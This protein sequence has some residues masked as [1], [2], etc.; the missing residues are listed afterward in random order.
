[1]AQT[2]WRGHLTFGLVSFPVRLYK[3]ARAEKVS[4]RRLY[5]PSAPPPPVFDDEEPEPPPPPRR[6]QKSPEPIRAT[7]PAPPAEPEVFRTQNRIVAPSAPPPAAARGRD[8]DEDDA[9]EFTPSSG[10]LVKG[11]EYEKGRYVVLEDEELKSLVPETSKEMQVVEFVR[12]AE[13]DPIFFETSYYV[14]P[15]EAGQRPY[16]LLFEALREAEYVGLAQLAMHRREHIVVIRSGVAGLTAHTMFFNDEIRREQE[17]RADT[18]DLNPRELDLAKRLIETMAVPFEPEKF[19]DTYR[20][21]LQQMIEAKVAGK[22]VAREKGAAPKAPAAI[23]IFDALQ[24]S[25]NAMKKPAAAAAPSH[26]HA[27]RKRA[28]KAG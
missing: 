12:L 16:S 21:R 24:K 3:A 26:A 15:D 25:L 5:R 18:A 13:I 28:R 20:E 8:E 6:G 22:E 1:M 19:R 23:D 10:E 9:G 27:A 2:V 17:Y 7:A 4:L 14:V 11:Y